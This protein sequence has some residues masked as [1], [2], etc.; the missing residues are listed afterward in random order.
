[1]R[2]KRTYF[3]LIIILIV[4]FL[5][6]FFVFGTDNI[7]VGKYN[8]TLLV[9]EDTVWS[10]SDKKWTNI[11]KTTSIQKLNWN[12]F[13]VYSN[14]EKVGEYQLW[15]SDKWYAFDDDNNAVTLDGDFLAYKSN[16]TINVKGFTEEEITDSTYVDYVLKENDLSTS[17]QF[18][19]AYKTSFDFDSDGVEE[20]FYVISNAFPTDFEP[21]NIFSIVFMVKDSTVYYI[22]NDISKNVSFNGC[23]PF[24]TSFIDVDEDD[25][26]EFILGCGRYSVSEQ[27]NMLYQFEEDSFKIIISNQ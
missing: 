8:T 3:I 9:G 12:K 1:M 18:T 11:T 5:V 10:Y 6:M 19:S 16:H 14:N 27:V 21:E 2:N 7:K 24:L 20:D 4:F 22:Y 23:K 25:V 26:Y 15:Y 17:S 13:N